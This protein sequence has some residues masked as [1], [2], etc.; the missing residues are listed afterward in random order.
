MREVSLQVLLQRTNETAS[1]LEAIE[2]NASEPAEVR[3]LRSKVHIHIYKYHKYR[4]ICDMY[5]FICINII[6]IDGYVI[7]I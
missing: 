1:K 2:T 6:N 7:Y 5:L 3:D 4:W